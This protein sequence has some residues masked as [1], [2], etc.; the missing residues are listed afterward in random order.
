VLAAFADATLTSDTV[1]FLDGTQSVIHAGQGDNFI[2]AT[3]I[4]PTNPALNGNYTIDGGSSDDIIFAGSGNVMVHGGSGDDLIFAGSG[5]AQLYGDAGVD[6][7]E[8]NSTGTNTLVG[9]DG[10]DALIVNRAGTD[11]L[12]GGEGDDLFVLKESA[13]LIASGGGFNFGQ[14]T[15]DGGGGRDTLR[16]IINDQNPLAEQAFI[17][18]FHKVEAAFD[19][20]AKEGHPGTFEVD[21][22]QVTGV[23]RIELQIDSVSN[24]PNRPYLITHHIAMA[25]GLGGHESSALQQLLQTA[26]HWNL[27]TA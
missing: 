12:S 13:G 19:Q 9:G 10:G 1:Q 5:N 27:L 2:F 15:I 14:Q 24:N 20:A 18:E 4:D 21:G 8:T 17:D 23:E 16:F 22:L 11:T 3:P 26:D 25:D 7:L 6:V